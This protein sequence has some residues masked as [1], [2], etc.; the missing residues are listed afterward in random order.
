MFD[1]FIIIFI[2]FPTQHNLVPGTWYIANTSIPGK[3]SQAVA[4]T[5]AAGYRKL[6]STCVRWGCSGGQHLSYFEV[7]FFVVVSDV[8][9]CFLFQ[10]PGG[11]YRR[12]L[13]CCTAMSRGV[14]CFFGAVKKFRNPRSLLTPFQNR[15]Y[16]IPDKF[17]VICRQKRG[18]ILTGV[19]KWR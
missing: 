7:F 3:D 2:C 10:S 16:L 6:S 18:C 12:V 14:P 13:N 8:C 15:K 17:Q 11:I 9:V 5:I 1:G 4:T 19:K